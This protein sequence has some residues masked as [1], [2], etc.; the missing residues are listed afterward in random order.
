M[1][2]LFDDDLG[3]DREPGH[4]GVYA[5]DLVAEH[6]LGSLIQTAD[7]HIWFIIDEDPGYRLKTIHRG[8]W[9]AAKTIIRK[10]FKTGAMPRRRHQ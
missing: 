9:I 1:R 3:E 5:D 2:I 7:G 6:Y 10:A 8:D 4:V